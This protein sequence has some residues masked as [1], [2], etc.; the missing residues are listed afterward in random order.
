M[1]CKKRYLEEKLF[2][3][4]GK[5]RIIIRK[6][7]KFLFRLRSYLKNDLSGYHSRSFFN[8][9]I[10]SLYKGGFHNNKQNHR[11]EFIYH[12]KN[13]YSDSY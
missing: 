12:K 9:N 2:L 7:Y 13:S 10:Y 11:G 1:R 3:Y 6:F 8:K 4:S 5:N